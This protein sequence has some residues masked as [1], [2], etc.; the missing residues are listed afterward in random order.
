MIFMFGNQEKDEHNITH[1]KNFREKL[2]SCAGKGLLLDK[3]FLCPELPD[4][5]QIA[6]N[7]S[8]GFVVTKSSSSYVS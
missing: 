8:T 3:P 4:I 6:P 7:L 2:I 5:S 1:L